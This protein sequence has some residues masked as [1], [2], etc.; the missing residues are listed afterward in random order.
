MQQ[1]TKDTIKTV[2]KAVAIIVFVPTVVTLAYIGTKKTIQ[3]INKRKADKLAKEEE[4]NKDGNRTEP[5]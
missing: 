2:A 5:I 3:F 4:Q 1:S